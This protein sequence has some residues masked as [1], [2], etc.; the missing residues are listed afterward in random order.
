MSVRTTRETRDSNTREKTARKVTWTPP[1]RLGVGEPPE[2]YQ[3]RWVRYETVGRSDNPNV[4]ERIQQ[5]YEIVQAA[6]LAGGGPDV[7]DEGR[8]AG[9]VRSG[10][11]VLTKVPLEIVEQRN[12]YYQD[13]TDQQHAA[14]S[15]DRNKSSYKTKEEQE[16]MPPV[17]DT[18][19]SHSFAPGRGIKR[20]QGGFDNEE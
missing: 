13:Q 9:A 20:G 4:H 14:V 6:D 2:G 15:Q 19:S 3:Y 18:E 8:H 12:Q 10:D 11:L 5:G 16:Y 17:D 7:L 1:N